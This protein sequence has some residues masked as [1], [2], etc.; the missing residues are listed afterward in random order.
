MPPGAWYLLRL[1]WEADGLTQSE[2]ARGVGM[3]EPTAVIALRNMQKAGWIARR[4]SRTDGRKVHIHLT[5]AGRAL[6]D[7]LLPEAH[8]VN[9][10]ALQALSADEAVMLRALLRRAR[11]NFSAAEEATP[12]A[13]PRPARSAPR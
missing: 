10:L 1:L 5:D 11:A 6:R 8:A 3:T 9:A 12:P 7:R 4:P 2:L 13:P